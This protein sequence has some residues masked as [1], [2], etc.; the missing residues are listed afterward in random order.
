MGTNP[1]QFQS[2]KSTNDRRPVE[3][4]SWYDAIS[5]CAKLS[6]KSGRNY[7]LPSEAQWEYACKAGSQSPFYCGATII[8]EL[9]NIRV[10]RTNAKSININH[11]SETSPVAKFPA[12]PWGLH[13]MHGNI[14]EWCLDHW[15]SRYHGASNNGTARLAP[16]TGDEDEEESHKVLRGGSWLKVFPWNCRSFSRNHQIPDYSDSSIGFRVVCLP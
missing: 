9:A 8:A 15:N 6:E 7:T 10:S 11:R 5:F 4:V 12:N 16:R 14:E 2:R 3:R 13:D 1:S